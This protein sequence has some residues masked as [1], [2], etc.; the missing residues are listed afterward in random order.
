MLL[1]Q[2]G[3]LCLLEV[4]FVSSFES[5]H[6][7]GLA[8]CLVLSY[9]DSQEASAHLPYSSSSHVSNEP[10]FFLG[11][12]IGLKTETWTVVLVRIQLL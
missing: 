4:L 11:G 7:C 6:Q 10:S 2:L 9:S 12:R 8:D 5:L 3:E 1:P